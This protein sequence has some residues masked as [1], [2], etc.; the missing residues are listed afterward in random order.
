[1]ADEFS[2]LSERLEDQRKWHSNKATW[3]KNRFYVV[4]IITLAAGAL[5]PIVNVLDVLPEGWVR[6]TSALLAS[7]IVVANGISKLY[8]FQEN[9][10]SF[11]ALAEVLKREKE[12]YANEIGEY[13][14]RGDRERNRILVER[15]EN[16]LAGTTSAFLSTHKRAKEEAPPLSPVT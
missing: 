4:E 7:A 13:A 10:L 8:K 15:V 16:L 2:Y 3:N 11:R 6:I 14:V 1:M 5:I 9:W 12:F